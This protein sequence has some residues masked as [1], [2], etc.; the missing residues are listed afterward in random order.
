MGL[1]VQTV[2]NQMSTALRAVRTAVTDSGT[3]EG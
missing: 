3:L 1:S 2:A